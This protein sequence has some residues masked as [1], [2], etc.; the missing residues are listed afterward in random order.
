MHN[1][2]P[3]SILFYVRDTLL[4]AGR[5]DHLAEFF[6][7]A[8]RCRLPEHLTEIAREYVDIS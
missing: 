7:R 6:A 3:F 5:D 1:E 2:R 4:Q 8:E